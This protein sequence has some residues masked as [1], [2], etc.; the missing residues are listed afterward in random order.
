MS[1]NRS[2]ISFNKSSTELN[3]WSPSKYQ[4]SELYTPNDT[5]K[6][7]LREYIGQVHIL[8]PGSVSQK[9]NILSFIDLVKGFTEQNNT[10]RCEK[11]RTPLPQTDFQYRLE[12]RSTENI[13][14]TST[15]QPLLR[16][17]IKLGETLLYKKVSGTENYHM[18]NIK[19]SYKPLIMDH[20]SIINAEKIGR[21]HV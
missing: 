19:S 1:Q 5:N 4:T 18:K 14:T 12:T 7:K 11:I 15:F 20:K 8:K 16:N 13:K 17:R 6:L 2:S 9:K 3:L 10:S 21:A